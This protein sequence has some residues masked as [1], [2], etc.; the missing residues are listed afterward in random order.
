VTPG[1]DEA[2]R[3]ALRAAFV[4]EARRR[5]DTLARGLDDDGVDVEALCREAHTLRGSAAVVELDGVAELAAELESTLRGMP[6]RARAQELVAR[7]RA[8]VETLPAGPVT[9]EP[10]ER[11]GGTTVVLYVEDD[12]PNALLVERLLLQRPGVTMMDART[13]AEG[14]RLAREH[15][16]ALVLLDLR[17]PDMH[18]L[19]VVERLRNDPTT[20]GLPI[21]VISGG[22]EPEVIERLRAAGVTEVMMK[23]FDVTRLLALVDGALAR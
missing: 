9:E 22:A 5:L 11:R 6:D 3:A 20:S 16:P 14:M 17:L 10:A 13:G 21:A 7:L 8:R 2:D 18:G 19:E 23:P 4:P 15:R 1:L 12:R